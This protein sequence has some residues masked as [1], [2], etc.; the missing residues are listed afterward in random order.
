[1]LEIQ[2]EHV[3]RIEPEPIDFESFDPR[4]DGFEQ[5]IPDLGVADIQLDQIVMPR[6]TLVIKRVARR[7]P[8]LKIQ[9]I[10]TA[11]ARGRAFLT[12]IAKRP[13]IA[14]T[15]I[16]HRIKNNPDS[17]PMKFVADRSECR[18][19]AEPAINAKIINDVITVAARLKHGPKQDRI[20][21][22]TSNVIDPLHKPGKPIH[23]RP[24]ERIALRRTQASKGKEMI[25]D[26]VVR[27]A[28][29]SF[30]YIHCPTD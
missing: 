30:G 25:E 20:R 16:K 28:T 8:P 7:T 12:N 5:M 22:Q 13:E 15:V 11:I 2:V 18:I 21:T 10:P 24:L 26:R 27:P 23:R 3:G 6:P 4:T 9:V 14:T 17:T 29:H 19:I 1:M